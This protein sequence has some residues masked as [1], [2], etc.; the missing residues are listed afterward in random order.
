V[1]FSSI[2]PRNALLASLS[3]GFYLWGAHALLRLDG[4][5]GAG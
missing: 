1:A 3:L 2:E 5:A 4:D